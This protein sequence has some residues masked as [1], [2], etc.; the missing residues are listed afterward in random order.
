MRAHVIPIA[1]KNG[2]KTGDGPS[3]AEWHSRIGQLLFCD[4][5]SVPA[6]TPCFTR[7]GVVRDTPHS[8]RLRLAHD[9]IV[10]IIEADA[11]WHAKYDGAMKRLRGM[12]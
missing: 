8:E 10:G 2:A 5:C 11:E 4:R 12:E 1:P 6:G 7:S 3:L 9:I